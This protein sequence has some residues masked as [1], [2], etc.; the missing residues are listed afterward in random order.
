MK[1]PSAQTILRTVIQWSILSLL[2][3]KVLVPAGS[4]QTVYSYVNENGVRVL[5]NIPPKNAL[6][7]DVPVVRNAPDGGVARSP[8]DPIGT[9]SIM[10]G[11][12][13][14]LPASPAGDARTR[15]L[16]YDPIIEKYAQQ[17]QLDPSLVRSI[18]ATESGFNPRAVSRKGARGLMQLMPDTAARL[19][20]RNL[21]D[22]DENI[23]GG[24]KYLRNLL[25][26]FNNDLTLSLAAY[27]AGENL[28]QRLGR[29]PNIPETHAYVLSVQ[30]RYGQKEMTTVVP[31]Q[32]RGPSLFRFVDGQGVLHLTDKPP[33]QRSDGELSGWGAGL[34][35]SR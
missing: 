20:V 6:P 15:P 2:T 30:K 8:G 22:A 28:V 25:D 18:I 16:R 35:A 3:I 12:G 34:P 31:A 32:P 14:G 11:E 9:D 13:K 24:T 29:I 33:I 5:T 17:Y 19:G 7:P 1:T 10:R 23:K 27:N 4:A 26:T 21:H